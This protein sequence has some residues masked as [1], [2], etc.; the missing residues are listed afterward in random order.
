[1]MAPYLMR[2]TIF[3]LLYVFYLAAQ[4]PSFEGSE[5][6]R[7]LFIAEY[8]EKKVN[9]K[10]PVTFSYQLYGGYFN[11]P[12]GRMALP[13]EIGVGYS[14][15]P[16]FSL[17]N[18]RAQVIDRFECSFNYRIFHNV[19]DPCLTHLGFGDLSDRTVNMKIALFLPEDTDYRLPGFAFGFDDFLGT[20]NFTAQYLVLTQVH[21]DK[22]L[23][24]SLG[25]GFQRLN[26]FFA[27]AS[28]W[29]FWK[30]S[31]SLLKPLSF[32]IEYDPICYKREVHPDNRTQT[33][34]FNVGLKYRLG[35]R[36]DATVSYM[37]GESVAFSISSFYNLGHT[38][39]VLP[40][41]KDPVPYRPPFNGDRVGYTGSD[42]DLVFQL[43]N[44]MSEQGFDLL[45]LS[46]SSDFL[47]QKRLRLHVANRKW[48]TE[49]D[50][51]CRLY[52]MLAYL[53]PEEIDWVSV[54]KEA[55][56]FAIQEYDFPMV[57]IRQK[58]MCLMG[59][60]E[61]DVL[62]PM[63][64][65]SFPHHPSEILYSKRR[66]LCNFEIFPKTRL[67]FGSATGKFKYAL[68]LTVGV[69]GFFPF[70]D[71]YYSSRI[72]V[73]LFNNLNEVC[74]V[75]KLNPSQIINVRTDAIGYYKVKGITLDECYLQKVWSLRKGMFFRLAGGYFEQM[76]GGV[77]VES[78]Y[79]PVNSRFALGGEF[80]WVKKRERRGFGFE[81]NVRK[82]SGFTKTFVPFTGTQYF[83]NLYYDWK[84]LELDFRIQ[85]GKFLANDL[86]A[87]FEISRYFCSGLRMLVWFSLTDGGD[88]I[89]GR[90]YHDKGIALSMPLDIF[91]THSERDR[92]RYS[93]G[94]WLRDVGQ[95]AYTGWSL[96]D[97]INEERQW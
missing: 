29:P 45:S 25:Y 96:Y 89:N 88:R 48:R 76:Y 81:E 34:P 24:W 3:C 83:C 61:L 44:V 92:W 55:N 4:D 80:A 75:D 13:G 8:W 9:E 36:F 21:I 51:R 49:R 74:S 35:D 42:S 86:G 91:Y 28:W 40:K 66:E 43:K 7:D 71:I 1:M 59:S 31:F 50:M 62:V 73:N 57:Y 52:Y 72:G 90:E 97:Q 20:R 79:F 46:R 47:G 22:G 32:A 10:L 11:M 15:V 82:L 41:L 93:L 77:G 63:K 65:V 18:L 60:A 17:Y 84:E 68:G 53:I 67:L 19:V 87:R 2:R 14:S 30:S 78:L 16:P 33:A 6:M 12:S 26:G 37:K 23:E 54:V 64:N 69:N 58:K 38:R 85:V 70:N 5:L 27:A 39:G 56:G 95:T 94:A